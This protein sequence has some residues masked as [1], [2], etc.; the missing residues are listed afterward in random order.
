MK[1]LCHAVQLSLDNPILWN[2][3]EPYLYELSL[4][5]EN[6]VIVDRVGIREI[7]IEDKIIY[8][9]QVPIKF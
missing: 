3:E 9:N 2:S 1:T 8:I 4:E 7:Y 6:E 5:T